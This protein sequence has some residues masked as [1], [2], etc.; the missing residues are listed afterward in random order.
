MPSIEHELP[1]DLIRNDP[2]FAVELVKEVRGEPLPEH[3]R[4]RCD[5]SEATRTA[6]S[7]LIT[8]SLVVCERPP[9]PHEKRTEPVPV[10]GI[11]TE[12]QHTWDPRKSYSWPCYVAN[13][14]TDSSA[15]SCFWCSPPP[16]HWGDVTPP[17]SI[18]AVVRSVPW[19][20][21]WTHSGPSPT[22]AWR[23]GIRC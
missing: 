17:P 20:L 13:I 23:P 10:L 6:P 12:P 4:V 3:T 11:I 9:L 18:W 21:P 2:W 19:S 15:R 14:L 7:Q 5:A 22:R 1:L 16:P 8:D